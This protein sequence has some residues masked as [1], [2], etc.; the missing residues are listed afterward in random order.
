[1]RAVLLISVM[2]VLLGLVVGQFQYYPPPCDCSSDENKPENCD[3]LVADKRRYTVIPNCDCTSG[4]NK[5]E[6]CDVCREPVPRK[7]SDLFT[8]GSL[9]QSTGRSYCQCE[10]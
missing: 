3:G 1:M 7:T 6:S 4:V 8:P 9:A 5:P 2:Y 10:L